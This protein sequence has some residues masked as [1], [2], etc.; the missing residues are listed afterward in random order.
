MFF[1]S[2]QIFHDFMCQGDLECSG[3]Y[4]GIDQGFFVKIVK[5]KYSRV[6]GEAVQLILANIMAKAFKL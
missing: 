4:P 3:V 6:L 1:V 2:Q 5:L